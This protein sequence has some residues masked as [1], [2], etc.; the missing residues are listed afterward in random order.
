MTDDKQVEMNELEEK[1]HPASE[2]VHSSEM[3][4]TTETKKHKH[5]HSSKTRSELEKESTLSSN[6]SELAQAL[7]L[8]QEGEQEE[9]QFEG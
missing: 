2:S 1:E 7:E 6:P 5:R 8:S 9:I 4:S 3:S